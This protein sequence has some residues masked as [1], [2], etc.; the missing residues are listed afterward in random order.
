M[1]V[2]YK[3]KLLVSSWV[4]VQVR[5]TSKDKALTEVLSL[6]QSG[7]LPLSDLEEVEYVDIYVLPE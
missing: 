6:I 4:A 7:Q 1:N 5:T 2:T 3:V